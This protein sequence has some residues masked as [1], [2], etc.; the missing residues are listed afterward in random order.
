M[1]PELFFVLI[2]LVVIVVFFIVVILVIG[3]IIFYAKKQTKENLKVWS[4]LS[5]KLNLQMLNPK[6]FHLSGKYNDLEVEVKTHAKMVSMYSRME[7]YQFTNCSAK[8][9]QPLKLS[10][11]LKYPKENKFNGFTIGQ[12]EFDSNFNVACP[13]QATLQQL[14]SF[15]SATNKNLLNDILQTKHYIETTSYNPALIKVKHR[16]TDPTFLIT[17]DA[18]FIEVRTKFGDDSS[19]I[20]QL[21]NVTTYLA[22]QIYTARSNI[23]L[24]D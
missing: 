8:F 5:E 3:G 2:A 17:D 19:Q 4:R 10:L 18:V 14:L 7:S 6:D 20:K 13:N 12:T 24:N 9:P 1:S 16:K 11:N 23:R 15:N 22:K 21:L